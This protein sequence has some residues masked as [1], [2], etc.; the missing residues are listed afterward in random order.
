[1]R[2]LAARALCLSMACGVPSA[3]AEYETPEVQVY[4]RG[5]R[6]VACHRAARRERVVGVRANDGMGTDESTYVRSGAVAGAGRA[7]SPTP[8]CSATSI[9]WATASSPTTAPGSSG[10][11]TW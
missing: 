2:V 3:Q 9:P 4:V 8:A 1:M 10:R 6:L 7:G 5:S 11:S